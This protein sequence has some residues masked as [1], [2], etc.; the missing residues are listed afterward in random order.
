MD[1]EERYKDKLVG[2]EEAVALIRSGDVVTSNFGGSIPYAFL[3]ALA[4][5]AAE[6]L[7]NVTLYLAGFYKETRIAAKSL[8]GH[9]AVRS[10]FLGPCERA[11]IAAGA[12]ISYQSMHLANI[13]DDRLGKHRA[14]VL[15]AAG[16]VPDEN[17]RISLGVAPF[18]PILL[19]V[20][21]TVII[22]VNRNM[23]FV[24][25]EDCTIPVER[26]SCLIACDEALPAVCRLFPGACTGRTGSIS[27][28]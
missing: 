15:V 7:E 25:G 5:Y 11:A 12:D 27:P 4:D 23:P 3:D 18:D 1:W 6:H 26:V 10:C 16:S 28:P 9:I 19:D 17:G 22:Q 20:C 14:R 8:N 2:M 13:N 21:E 24:F